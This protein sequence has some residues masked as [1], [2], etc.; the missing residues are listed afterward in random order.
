MSLYSSEAAISN[1][2]NSDITI[3]SDLIIP[4]NSQVIFWD[5]L[6]ESPS[7]IITQNFNNILA[8][9][10]MLDA[11]YYDGYICCIKDNITLE[12]DQFVMTFYEMTNLL[13]Q[14]GDMERLLSTTTQKVDVL[15]NVELNHQ[16]EKDGRLLV[17]ISP[18]GFGWTTWFT[19]SSDSTDLMEVLMG[20]GRGGGEQIYIEMDGPGTGNM[21]VR[22]KECIQLHEGEAFW[23]NDGYWGPRDKFSFGIMFNATPVTQLD[24]P[25]GNCNLFA[26]PHG[27]N[28]IIPAAD[29]DGYHQVNLG[30]NFPFDIGNAVPI[31]L[32]SCAE[33]E[34]KCSGFW[35]VDEYTGLI[36]PADVP[37]QGMYNLYDAEMPCSWFIKNVSMGSPARLF[38]IKTYK[39]TYIHPNWCIHIKVEKVSPGPGWF[40]GWLMTFR[41]DIY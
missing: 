28:V 11:A 30:N 36:R 14:A 25:T 41:R 6:H 8:N 40:S 3:C 24:E 37:G 19:G 39:A 18:V 7:P 17:S 35:D 26:T 38:G 22:F 34:I 33:K 31:P 12:Y 2:T 15:N 9:Y 21:M 23:G 5:T 27:F 4:A 29:N 20:G 1:K 32:L 10:E 16:K 13:D